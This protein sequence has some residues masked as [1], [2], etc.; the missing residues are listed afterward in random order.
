MIAACLALTLGACSTVTVHADR[1]RGTALVCYLTVAHVV[2]GAT[3]VV[4]EGQTADVFPL[5]LDGRGDGPVLLIPRGSPDELWQPVP[6]DSGSPIY[7]RQGR[8]VGLHGGKV[9]PKF[10][11][12]PLEEGW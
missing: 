12:Y 2:S 9:W 5:A 1:R 11:M 10:Y 3:T 8:V 4:V 6:G 7:D